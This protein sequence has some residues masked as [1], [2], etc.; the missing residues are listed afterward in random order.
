MSCVGDWRYPRLQAQLLVLVNLKSIKDVCEKIE[1]KDVSRIVIAISCK[2]LI[3][4]EYN[5]II[6]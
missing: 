2:G 1:I 3:E 5:K 6:K 4:F